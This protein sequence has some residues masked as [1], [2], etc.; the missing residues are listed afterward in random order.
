VW[1]V[2]P[3]GALACIYVM[4]GLPTTAWVRFGVWMAAGMVIYFAFGYRNSRLV[5]VGDPGS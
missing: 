2:A 1:V 4:T 5:R 3:L